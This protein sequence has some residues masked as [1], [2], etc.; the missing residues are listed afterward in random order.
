MQAYTVHSIIG[1]EHSSTFRN[2][3]RTQVD[4]GEAVGERDLLRAEVLLDCHRIVCAA[5][6]CG[7]VAHNHAF[8]PEGLWEEF[9]RARIS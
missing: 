3:Q 7:V 4:A 9:G 1:Q 5:L 2:E 8:A 6:H